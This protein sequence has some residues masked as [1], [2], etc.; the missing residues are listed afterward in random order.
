VR[1]EP[2]GWGDVGLIMAVAVPVVAVWLWRVARWSAKHPPTPDHLLPRVFVPSPQDAGYWDGYRSGKRHQEDGHRE[3]PV[4]HPYGDAYR[5]GF[6][7]GYRASLMGRA[8]A[9]DDET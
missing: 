1:P 7:D 3:Y 6:R 8:R 2:F 4:E 5:A 9:A